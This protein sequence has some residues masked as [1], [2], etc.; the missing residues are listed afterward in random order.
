MILQLVI[1]GLNTGLL[2]ALVAL[3]FSLIYSGT[4]ILHIAHGAI[5][6]LAPYFFLL[7]LSLTG[8]SMEKVGGLGIF[9]I[10]IIVTLLTGIVAVA[11]ET[12]VYQPLVKQKASSLVLLISSLGV[13]II[14][15]NTIAIVSGNDIKRL[16]NDIQPAV[17]MGDLFLTSIQIIQFGVSAAIIGLV[18]ALL[19]ITSIGRSIRA[20]CDD[21]LLVEVLGGNSK[22]IRILIFAGGSIMCAACGLLIAFDVG[23]QP[24]IGL[25]MMLN[26]AVAVIIGGLY[27][28]RGA[29]IGAVLLGLIHVASSWVFSNEWQNATTF[30]VL[31]GVLL[32]RREGLFMF[33][34]RAE[35]R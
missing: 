26:G 19:E 23:V 3:G 12:V 11:I 20:L 25:P 5:F 1:N 29:V 27:S 14:I 7:A 28:Y 2:Y 35:E 17:Q 34:K 15:I 13:Y 33:S 21:P 8:L 24:Q 10:L 18:L 4:R 30:V 9:G 32:V 31:A 6:T 16:T 22:F